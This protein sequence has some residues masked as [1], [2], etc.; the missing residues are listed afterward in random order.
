MNIAVINIKTENSIKEQA[1]EV[2]SKLGLSLSALINAYLRE[3]IKTKQVTFSVD[4]VPSPYLVSALKQAEKNALKKKVSPS[5]RNAKDAISWL[6][7][8][9]IRYQN[10]NKV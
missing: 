6:E 1:Q 10:G 3:L 5:F 8:S 2:A 7:A 9:K 4:E